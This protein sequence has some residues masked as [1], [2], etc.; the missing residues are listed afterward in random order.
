MFPFVG[1]A[2]LRVA[3]LPWSL[4]SAN[5]LWLP[6]RDS[7]AEAQATDRPHEKFPPYQ[8]H[9]A[10]DADELE[11]Y[12]LFKKSKARVAQRDDMKRL[13]SEDDDKHKEHIDHDSKHDKTVASVLAQLDGVDSKLYDERI[14]AVQEEPNL[15]TVFYQRDVPW[16]ADTW[17]FLCFVQRSGEWLN[18]ESKNLSYSLKVNEFAALTTSESVSQYTG[19]NPN[20]VWSGLKSTHVEIHDV[21]GTFYVRSTKLCSAR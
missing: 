18:M 2:P 5:L 16:N 19:Y 4:V 11:R 20:N 8:K 17:R 1:N 6:S 12:G 21:G 7:G 10:N 15:H 3:A 14:I 9:Y 13:R